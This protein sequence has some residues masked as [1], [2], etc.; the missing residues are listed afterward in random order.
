M[1]WRGGPLEHEKQFGD[2]FAV[3]GIAARVSNEEANKIGDLWQRWH[4]LGDR[5][6]VEARLDET[7]YSV[8]CEYEGDASRPY[9]VVIGCAVPADAVVP[10]GLKKIE[11][12]AGE[13]AVFP[14]T[15]P[16]PMGV[17]ATWS[18]VWTTPLDRRYKADFDRY[19]QDGTV[20]VHVG[21]PLQAEMLIVVETEGPAVRYGRR[22]DQ[23]DRLGRGA[24][25]GG[26]WCAMYGVARVRRHSTMPHG[27]RAVDIVRMLKPEFDEAQVATGL[28]DIEDL[29]IADKS[30]LT[31]LP[32]VKELLES[33]PVE[34]WAIVTS[35]TRRLLLARLWRRRGCR[36]PE[37]LDHP[38]RYGGAGASPIREPYRRGAELLGFALRANACCGGGCAFRSGCGCGCR[39]P[40]VGSCGDASG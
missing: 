16:L 10:E 12:E 36:C 15:G 18:E 2:A 27:M 24:G 9:T 13:F 25:A 20:S 32:G 30:D 14:V 22:V 39:V 19:E 21:V 7:I 29:E 34:R 6:I 35:C 4:A 33:L 1:C 3:M 37:Q 17:V 5:K 26:G 11:V 28:R 31:V 38:R 8:Y 40:G 23:F